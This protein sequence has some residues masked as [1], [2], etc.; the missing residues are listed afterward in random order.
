MLHQV[1]KAFITSAES[2]IAHTCPCWPTLYDGNAVQ[3]LHGSDAEL[4]GVTKSQPEAAH[5][6][7]LTAALRQAH[8]PAA[9]Q[10]CR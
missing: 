2:S 8:P 3:E 7:Q 10:V 1:I 4:N 9:P 6:I 5:D